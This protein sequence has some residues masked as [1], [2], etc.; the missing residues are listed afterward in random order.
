MVTIMDVPMIIRDLFKRVR[1]DRKEP[2][3][4]S[5]KA[6]A[7]FIGRDPSRVTRYTQVPSNRN[8]APIRPADFLDKTDNSA[9]RIGK[10]KLTRGFRLYMFVVWAAK[11]T[12]MAD[13]E[14]FLKELE[15]WAGTGHE[16][17]LVVWR[18]NGRTATM[19][20]DGIKQWADI[21]WRSCHTDPGRI[22]IKKRHRRTQEEIEAAKAMQL[23]LDLGQ[24]SE[25]VE[26]TEIAH[27]QNP[28]P[29]VAK[30][31]TIHALRAIFAELLASAD[32][33]GGLFSTMRLRQ[34]LRKNGKNIPHI[35]DYLRTAR[36]R[37]LIRAACEYE[38]A[39]VP[40]WVTDLEDNVAPIKDII[41]YEKGNGWCLNAPLFV[42]YCHSLD[43]ALSY[44][45]A[46]VFTD[47]HDREAERAQHF[48]DQDVVREIIAAELNNILPESN[49][50]QT[51]EA[52]VDLTDKV[53][54]LDHEVAKNRAGKGFKKEGSGPAHFYTKE[55]LI[56]AFHAYLMELAGPDRNV[57]LNSAMRMVD[58]FCAKIDYYERV[59]YTRSIKGP[60][61]LAS[62]QEVD[63]AYA[64]D[65]L[66]KIPSR[67][68]YRSQ[69]GVDTLYGTPL[70]GKVQVEM[71]F[72]QNVEPTSGKTYDTF[73]S[74]LLFF[75]ALREL[76]GNVV[77][78]TPGMFAAAR[79]NLWARVNGTGR[80]ALQN[81]IYEDLIAVA[82]DKQKAGDA[83][84]QIKAKCRALVADKIV[85]VPDPLGYSRDESIL[86][87]PG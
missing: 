38:G 44:V 65:M 60:E 67:M 20:R 2:Y 70:A 8:L 84:R 11:A 46:L 23:E 53:D 71:R 57:P 26:T 85:H 66:C 7:Q 34:E 72:R 54:F 45:C 31:I 22:A 76:S 58:Y 19:N 79:D 51:A 17:T 83:L 39:D 35:Y 56:T 32:V 42:S 52:L 24:E 36:A 27:S 30:G 47:R 50:H 21:R 78:N 13:A 16:D 37:D 80:T 64:E 18:S 48:V 14:E 59:A 12:G 63:G 40:S 74:P 87:F 10:E 73:Y 41:T 25:P 49:V 28:E 55:I 62:L 4:R 82:T 69:G 3:F 81:E 9:E 29:P 86:W 33:T 68:Q 1:S 75:E 43:P 5:N 61:Y 77:Y 6:V 15:A